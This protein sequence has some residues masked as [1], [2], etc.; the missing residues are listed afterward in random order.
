MDRLL[1]RHEPACPLCLLNTVRLLCEDHLQPFLVLFSLKV[2]SLSVVI[3]EILSA[4]HTVV[5]AKTRL[6]LVL[7]LVRQL[8]EGLWEHVLVDD[9]VDH[10]LVLARASGL[11]ILLVARSVASSSLF[12]AHYL[13][14]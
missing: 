14:I 1:G 6:V 7:F 10:A 13:K 5:L 2:H 3:Y 8:L 4:R 11:P 12:N 9:L